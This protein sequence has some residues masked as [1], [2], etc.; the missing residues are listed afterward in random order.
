MLG[1]IE[2]T[3]NRIWKTPDRRPWFRRAGLYLFF[4]TVGPLALA[5]ALAAATTLDLPLSKVFPT[6]TPFFFIL[7]G[8]FYGMYRYLP[9]RAVYW[10]AA[11]VASIGTSS[12]W[13]VAKILYG[14]Y[15]RKFVTYDRVYGSL[16]AVPIFLVWTYVAWLVVLTGAAFSAS[17][18]WHYFKGEE[19]P[20][21][22]NRKK[23]QSPPT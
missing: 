16:G 9:Y 12:V 13:T 21:A 22:R 7:V 5:L 18:Q 4:I 20:H 14:L 2:Q 3:V 10:R 11:L 19:P 15:V 23:P 17:L 1:R 6:G 8:I